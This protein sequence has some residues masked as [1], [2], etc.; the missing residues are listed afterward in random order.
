MTHRFPPRALILTLAALSLIAGQ[1]DVFAR[2][3]AKPAKAQPV[4]ATPVAARPWLYENS[5]VPVDAAWRF[6]T[7]P[8]GLRYAVRR[9]SVPPGLLSIRV[10]V[11]AGSLHEK[12]EESGY[13][14]FIE[15]LTFR[16]SKFV[17]DGES[18]RIWQRLGVTFGSDSNAQTTPTATTYALDLP[19]ASVQG[20]E[21]S[22]KIL[23][24]MMSDP[25]IV[26]AAV[27]AERAVVLAE[28]RE[29]EGATSRA[30]DAAR[31]L[32]FAGQPLGAHAPI[33]TV[34]SLRAASAETLRAFH[35]R[36]Y[37]PENVVIAVSGDADPKAIEALILKHFSGW[38]SE[39]PT[40]PAPDFGKPDP[41]APA[42]AVVVQPG[43]HTSVSL[44]WL[45][46]W[47]AKADTIVYNQ[48][49]LADSVAIQMINRR[50]EEAARRPGSAFLQASIDVDDTS[51]SANGT[52]ISII[53][54][55]EGWEAALR[56][57][58]AIVE[59]AKA[60]APSNE[61]IER[62]YRAFET[63]LAI[64]VE[65][66][67]T[68]AS[69]TQAGN[70]TMAVDIRETIVSPQVALDIYRSARPV[71]T[72]EFMLD[73]TRRMFS[74]DAMRALL[75]L[76]QEEPDAQGRLDAA[77]QGPVVAAQGVRITGKVVTM[78]D[79]PALPPAGIA[80]SR[81]PVG[82]LG[83]EFVTFANGVRMTL[84]ANEGEK[85]KV[86]VNV[87]FGHGL[88]DLSHKR[89][90][91]GWAAGYVLGANGIGSLGQRELDE[92]TNARRLGFD[93]GIDEE[94][95]ELSALTR[96]ADYRDQLRLFAAKLYAPGWDPA[97]VERVKAGMLAAY[98]SASATPGGVMGREL[99]WLL[100]KK[101]ARYRTP[102]RAEIAALTPDAFRT[103]WEPILASGPIEVQIFGDV[104]ADEAIDAV[105]QTFGALPAR[106]ERP[107]KRAARKARFPRHNAKPLMLTHT[108][109]ADQAAAVIAW[110]TGAGLA[111]A[112]EGRQLEILAQIINDRLFERLRAAEGVAYSP[113]AQA[114]W[115]LGFDRGRGYILAMSQL[116]PGSTD[117]FF[118]LVR[119]IAADL[120]ARP[121]SA[122][123][124][125]RVLAPMRQLLS[126]ASTGNAYWMDQMEGAAFDRRY[127]A[128]MTSLPRD[129]L[130]VSPEQLRALAAKYLVDKKSYSVVVLPQGK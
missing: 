99:G 50:L 36:W 3:P 15:H 58:R 21:E 98:D 16:G 55:A 71:M 84:F 6:G 26:P 39:G 95:F 9:N 127:V 120:A 114:D 103:F 79:L 117:Y 111:N 96:P 29:R 76:P 69:A 12:P 47:T 75:V 112:R 115:P 37:R 34:Q 24:G 45:R 53:P 42:S 25:N 89:A 116:K 73:A 108:G 62:E 126:R 40:V 17:P 63:S 122:D 78:A 90:Q 65:N 18:K 7:L 1:G 105:A 54:S 66:Q 46:A 19:D 35:E 123:E 67:D 68:E 92:L 61:E 33:G 22:V 118:T 27:E 13:A 48:R 72:P 91:P 124:L 100:R 97:P 28:M 83:M 87:R 94:A 82:A 41:A 86:R 23:A 5:D 93:F 110:P 109:D 113:G 129:L 59:D 102:D 32:F 106:A 80:V 10:R 85:G 11:D 14:H 130:S 2:A 31:A 56:E 57:V 121:V 44:A 77:M 128:A 119:E 64:D 104:K 20:L 4:A 43:T 107:V 8:N 60:S 74:G 101:D 38:K 49:K 70:L 81:T 52:Y 30:Q 88:L 125:Q 51:R